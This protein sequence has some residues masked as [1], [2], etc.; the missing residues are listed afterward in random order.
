MS[1]KLRRT[2][3]MLAVLRALVNAD[4]PVWGLQICRATAL[5]TSSVYPLLSRLE[6]R[7]IVGSHWELDGRPGPRR[8]LYSLTDEG[9]AWA[10]QQ[11]LTAAATARPA[12]SP[13]PAAD[14]AASPS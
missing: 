9:R 5:T 3:A 13:S 8:R 14:P 10:L 4:G 1:V 12:G 6:D 11:L 7:R 2:P